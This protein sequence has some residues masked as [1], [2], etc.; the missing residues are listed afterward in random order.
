MRRALLAATA[1]LSLTAP[2]RADLQFCNKTSYVLDIALAPGVAPPDDSV[3]R[4]FYL[5]EA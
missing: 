3:E 4:R 1:I 5:D 2:S